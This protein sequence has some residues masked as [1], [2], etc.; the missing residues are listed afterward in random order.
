AAAPRRPRL[1]RGDADR[2]LHAAPRAGQLEDAVRP[3]RVRA[4]HRGRDRNRGALFPRYRAQ[5]NRGSDPRLVPLR[6]A[7]AGIDRPD[8]AAAGVALALVC[9][10]GATTIVPLVY[11]QPYLYA[12]PAFAILSLALPL[13]YLNYALTHQ[14]I[15]WD[16]Q[17]TYL[18]IAV[19]AL[20]GNVAA[21]VV[22]V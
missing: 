2:L 15:G 17:G 3:G 1:C 12:A 7:G 9:S 5:R 20:V 16:G 22:L 6:H 18:L 14:V 4:A 19:V 11:G 13:F 10:F 8:L 21:N